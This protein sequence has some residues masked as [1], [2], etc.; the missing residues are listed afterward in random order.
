MD[1]VT[2]A[3]GD[4]PSERDAQPLEETDAPGDAVGD[5]E[6]DW[7]ALTDAQPL[8]DTEAAPEALSSALAEAEGDIDKVREPLLLAVVLREALPEIEAAG[9]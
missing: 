9:D 2:A 5:T 6:G 1:S 3:V 7:E 4:G 8:S